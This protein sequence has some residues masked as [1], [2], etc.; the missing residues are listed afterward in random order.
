MPGEA[1]LQ[2]LAGVGSLIAIA[3]V[4]IREIRSAGRED[5]LTGR[6]MERIDQQD[7]KIDALEK[8]NADLDERNEDLDGRL[9]AIE[10]DLDAERGRVGRLSVRLRAAI[11]FIERLMDWVV[12]ASDTPGSAHWVEV[13]G[14]LPGVP[15]ELLALLR[16]R[17]GWPPARKE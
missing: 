9:D 3:W 4:I 12:H 14:P 2:G 5:A 13:S 17:T 15:D 16:A 8:R 10:A 1:I 7:R 11:A 6:L